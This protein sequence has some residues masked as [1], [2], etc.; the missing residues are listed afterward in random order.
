VRGLIDPIWSRPAQ[1]AAIVSTRTAEGHSSLADQATRQ[2]SLADQA[3]RQTSLADQATRQT[4][5]ADQA[6][7][8][9]SPPFD[10]AN[11]ATHVGDNPATVASNRSKLEAALGVRD[12]T[13]LNQVH[14]TQ[15]CDL[16]E[17]DCP[18]TPIADAAITRSPGK[19]CAVLTADCLPVLFCDA[20]GEVVAAAH[21]GWRG[22]AHGVL[23]ASV[24]AMRVDCASIHA[25]IGPAIGP[26]HFEV[27][28]EVLDTFVSNLAASSQCFVRNARARWQADL[29]KLA[30]LR[31]QQMGLQFITESG[32]CTA[33]NLKQFYSH[34][35]ENGITGR[36]ASLIWIKDR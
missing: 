17:L 28:E 5:L 2:T 21:A 22:L 3:T 23:E 8:Q 9:T 1:V 33:S 35:A 27:G 14:G 29:P 32:I 25:Y 20:R 11:L 34:R 31:L 16:D 10:E 19:V 26:V 18:A 13:W 7:R 12:I 6:T 30:R 15:V 4:S 24:Q 36:F